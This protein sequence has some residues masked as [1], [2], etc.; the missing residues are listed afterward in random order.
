ML[1]EYDLEKGKVQG[2]ESKHH[3]NPNMGMEHRSVDR[4]PRISKCAL[5]MPF[6]T[7]SLYRSLKKNC[8]SYSKLYSD[9]KWIGF[10]HPFP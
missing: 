9:R 2:F 4:S 3:S 8:H 10:D 5:Q 6:Q 1:L 7:L